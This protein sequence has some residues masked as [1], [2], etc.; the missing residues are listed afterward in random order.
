MINASIIASA[1]NKELYKNENSEL[2]K[3]FYKI[4]ND[5]ISFL[6]KKGEAL[7][8]HFNPEI[9]DSIATLNSNVIQIKDEDVIE[10]KNKIN[11]FAEKSINKEYWLTLAKL[12]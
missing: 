7:V 6:M 3:G 10:L 11:S 2:K 1:Y 9:I 12:I 8:I 5:S 4:K